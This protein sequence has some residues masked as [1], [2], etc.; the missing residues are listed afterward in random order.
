[1][2]TELP[3]YVAS[4]LSAIGL[5]ARLHVV[6][7]EDISPAERR[8]FQLSVDGDWAAEY[9]A[10][11]AYL[12]EFFSCNG[13]TSNGYV[14]DP[15][16]DDQMRA[17]MRAQLSSPRRAA[18][19]WTAVDHRLVDQAAWVPTVAINAVE[20]VSKRLAGYQFNPVTGFLA[21][22]AWLR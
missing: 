14:C 12:P 18:A 3:A 5:R 7:Y 9:P 11:S 22:Q 16:L 15:A 19:L 2:P 1:M 8:R 13:G 17:A 21:D 10:A 20:L 6:P 4:A